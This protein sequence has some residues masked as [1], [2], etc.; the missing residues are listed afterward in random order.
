MVRNP[1]PLDSKGTHTRSRA[2]CQHHVIDYEYVWITFS[3]MTKI[4]QTKKTLV[5]P[6]LEAKAKVVL[7]EH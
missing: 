1:F 3:P 5:T 7:K 2:A 4:S 6:C